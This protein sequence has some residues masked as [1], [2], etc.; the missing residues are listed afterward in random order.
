MM[1]DSPP[2]YIEAENRIDEDAAE[3]IGEVEETEPGQSGSANFNLK[4]GKYLLVC[5]IPGH[6]L[7]G[8]WAFLTV[9]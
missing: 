7:S 6:Y 5:N 4:P 9:E 1:G 2:P 3:A 8:M